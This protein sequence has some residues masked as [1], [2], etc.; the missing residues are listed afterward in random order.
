MLPETAK[1]AIDFNKDIAPLRQQYF[2]MLTGASQ[3]DRSMAY[4]QEVLSPLRQRV[5][6]LQN[7]LIDMQ[8]QELL[9]KRQKLELKQQRDQMRMQ[10]EINDA[11]PMIEQ[12]LAEI[13]DD[14]LSPAEQR[15]QMRSF[16]ID[17]ADLLRDAS[18]NNMFNIYEKTINERA[19]EQAKEQA[20]R[21]SLA[22]MYLN[23]AVQSGTYNE[24]LDAGIRAGI[25]G[26]KELSQEM[27]RIKTIRELDALRRAEE[28]QREE[29]QKATQQNLADLMK[30]DASLL[31]KI[32][33][34]DEIPEGSTIPPLDAPKILSEEDRGTV[35]RVLASAMGGI[36]FTPESLGALEQQFNS[37]A[38]MLEAAKLAVARQRYESE[39]LSERTLTERERQMNSLIDSSFQ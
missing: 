26:A 24:Q 27:G 25:Y 31:E 15:Q 30:E 37:D 5:V 10:R 9:Y 21:D 6:G 32:R 17:N 33:L 22:N 35:L 18:V 34:V 23:N 28:E 12:R 8:R 4:D 38:E 3:F 20:K 1:M 11:K 7:S 36:P 39:G 13:A 16:A 19:A 2:P 14:N 29:E